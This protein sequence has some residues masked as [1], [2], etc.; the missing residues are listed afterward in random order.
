VFSYYFLIELL[1]RILKI[2]QNLHKWTDL[3]RG[4]GLKASDPW[5]NP[6]GDS[7]FSKPLIGFEE[8]V[9]IGQILQNDSVNS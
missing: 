9:L 4:T 3:I 7:D 1:R 2:A 5:L 6:V 8:S